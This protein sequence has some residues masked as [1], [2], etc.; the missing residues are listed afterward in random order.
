MNVKS[1]REKQ[2]ELMEKNKHHLQCP[3]CAS[4]VQI[5]NKQQMVCL[6]SHSF[7]IA[8][9]GYVF[10]LSKPTQTHYTKELFEQR[11]KINMYTPFYTQF[12][13]TLAT[14]IDTYIQETVAEPLQLADMGTGE[15]S[16][17][18]NV[19]SY[20][21]DHLGRSVNGIGMD[22]SKEG[23]MHA[24]KHDDTHIWLVADIAHS[25][26]APRSMDVV[27]NVLSPSNYNEFARIRSKNGVIMKVIPGIKYMKEMRQFF[28]SSSN[29]V[30]ANERV[31]VHFSDHF[32]IDEIVNIRESHP[33]TTIERRT[34]AKM[35]PLTWDASSENVDAFVATEPDEI[36]IDLDIIVGT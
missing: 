33:L 34:L 24:T 29:P 35:S 14:L 21:S 4:S 5:K 28:H 25:P 2:A 23:I 20:L 31:R 10:L 30:Q 1:K 27:L 7:D 17:L 36:T 16:H 12:Q 3:I 18:Q 19:T 13:R 22:I 9:Q 26:L 8:K 32:Q 6:H 11:R 15:G